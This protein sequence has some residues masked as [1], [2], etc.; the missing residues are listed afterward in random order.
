MIKKNMQ[1]DESSSDEE[2]IITYQ[3]QNRGSQLRSKS[4]IIPVIQST[5]A[6]KSATPSIN[7]TGRPAYSE[8][9]TIGETTPLNGQH[10][11]PMQTNGDISRQ[12]ETFFT[13]A[14]AAVA[15]PDGYQSHLSSERIDD[16]T[17]NLPGNQQNVENQHLLED[18]SRDSNAQDQQVLPLQPDSVRSRL[19][20][21]LRPRN[22]LRK[23]R[24]FISRVLKLL[25][26]PSM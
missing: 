7:E 20:P 23:P 6:A 2:L 13:P 16:E 18:T 15:Q 1:E 8:S 5:P 22:M 3:P 11:T 10:L 25:T 17:T 14:S 9:Q 4:K 26:T 12:R 19:R 21:G 24:R